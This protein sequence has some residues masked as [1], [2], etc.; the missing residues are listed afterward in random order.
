[1]EYGQ[2]PEG[3]QIE[4]HKP[5]QWAR[6]DDPE[7]VNALVEQNLNLVR[8]A[9]KKFSKGQQGKYSEEDW[10]DLRATC[11]ASLWRAVEKFDPSKGREFST[12]AVEAIRK[13]CI[14]FYR[15]R[16]GD[17]GV[18]EHRQEK[19][20]EVRRIHEALKQ[21]LGC[22]PTLEQVM[23]RVKVTKLAYRV[24]ID[25]ND[26]QEAISSMERISLSDP[27]FSGDKEKTGEVISLLF[28]GNQASPEILAM[29]NNQLDLIVSKLNGL[30]TFSPRIKR[31]R[32]YDQDLEI[33]RQYI[34]MTPDLTP[35]TEKEVAAQF[36][37][38]GPSV[39]V[40]INKIAEHLLKIIQNDED[41]SWLT[42]A[43]RKNFDGSAPKW[44]IN[45]IGQVAS[46]V[47][48]TGRVEE[49]FFKEVQ[50]P[51][52]QTAES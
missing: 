18:S 47:E 29:A 34:G 27:V 15:E 8:F 39:H 31:N 42:E 49:K 13:A 2:K 23:A 17:I 25:A 22:A 21:E 44:F 24:T 36:K 43:D 51:L 41:Q 1:M 14:R 50:A 5:D 7:I 33:F 40:K 37:M 3:H 9:I 52:D 11:R 30:L 10:E 28:D 26:V 4:W 46:L 19:W 12:Y 35:A 38:S 6:R 45:K 48:T 32:A 16:E 20:R